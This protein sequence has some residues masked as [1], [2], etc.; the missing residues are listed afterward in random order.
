MQRIPFDTAA[1]ARTIARL[2]GF[3]WSKFAL[4]FLLVAPYVLT[5]LLVG[6]WIMR[7]WA[8]AV[9]FTAPLAVMA[10]L[11]L[12]RAAGPLD[13]AMHVVRRRLVQLHWAFGLLYSSSYLF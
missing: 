11:P 4:A 3:R 12:W 2:L 5:V 6:A 10:F 9:I 1:G 13:P 8:L 7:P